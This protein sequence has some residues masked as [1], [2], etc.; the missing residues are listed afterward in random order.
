MLPLTCLFVSALHLQS[1]CLLWVLVRL[2]PYRNFTCYSRKVPVWY[3]QENAMTQISDVY[4]QGKI[5]PTHCS[6]QQDSR[7][8]S[9]RPNKAAPPIPRCRPEVSKV[10]WMLI[11]LNPGLEVVQEASFQ[12]TAR[13]IVVSGRDDHTLDIDAAWRTTMQTAERA[14]INWS[15]NH[16]DNS[17]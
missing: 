13:T 5:W 17:I 4:S 11:S 15:K 1:Q 3:A 8:I 10:F 9:L 7:I 14:D 2:W 6:K 12:S 16:M